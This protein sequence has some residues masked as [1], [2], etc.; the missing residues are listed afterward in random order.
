M[1][2][3]LKNAKFL[4]VEFEDVINGIILI[5]KEMAEKGYDMEKVT[6]DDIAH[7]AEIH[8]MAGRKE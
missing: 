8:L 3:R 5:S 4:K 2:S 1:K 6:F 7:Y